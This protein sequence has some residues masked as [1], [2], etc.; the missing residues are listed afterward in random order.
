M[1]IVGSVARLAGDEAVAVFFCPEFAH[2][3]FRR[4]WDGLPPNTDLAD[5]AACGGLNGVAHTICILDI[6]G[7]ILPK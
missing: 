2:D 3:P 7:L 4:L 1:C 5:N 6:T